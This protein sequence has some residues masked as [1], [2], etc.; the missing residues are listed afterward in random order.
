MIM[1]MG[2]KTDLKYFDNETNSFYEF[3]ASEERNE[4]KEKKE[5]N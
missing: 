4:R 5:T 1:E 3:H 2:K